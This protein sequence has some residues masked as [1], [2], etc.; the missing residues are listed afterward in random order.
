[1]IFDC[2]LF[3]NEF[4]LLE[5]RL[6]ELDSVVDKFVLVESNQ[7]FS[8]KEKPYYFLENKCRY[9]E[10]LHKIIQVEAPPINPVWW[11]KWAIEKHQ[12]NYIM[13]GLTNCVSDDLIM[14]S[15]VDEIPDPFWIPRLK[16]LSMDKP[17]VFV[18]AFYYYYLNG[19]KDKEWNG[20]IVCRYDQIKT[21]QKMRQRRNS[22]FVFQLC[23][24]GWHF[25]FLG[26]AE[27]VK[28]KIKAFSHRE[29][30]QSRYTNIFDIT[31]KII[32]G[33]DLFGRIGE[34]VTYV[35]IDDTFPK[36]IVNNK[37]KW[38]HLIREGKCLTN[39]TK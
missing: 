25:S 22:W 3:F 9:K 16:Y 35:P 14:I 21:P 39:H 32:M 24:A 34:N 6:R 30:N 10:W 29:F 37:E 20:T 38:K 19:R 4:D 2:F 27:K 15:D 5:I 33:K 28:E 7:T 13:K 12:R 31:E 36:A 11:D 18:Q 23:D 8:G 26:G 17:T 1:M